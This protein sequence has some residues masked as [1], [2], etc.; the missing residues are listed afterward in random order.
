MNSMVVYYFKISH[1]YQIKLT[2]VQI[3]NTFRGILKGFQGPSV[4]HPYIKKGQYVCPT[5]WF[6]FQQNNK[7]NKY[8]E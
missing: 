2:I 4:M 6:K 5:F 7:G 8:G 1:F 3:G